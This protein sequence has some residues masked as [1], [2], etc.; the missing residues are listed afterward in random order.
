MSIAAQSCS[1][2]SVD[3]K[4]DQFRTWRELE[5]NP[6]DGRYADVS[7]LQCVACERLWLQYMV[8]YEAFSKSG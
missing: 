8:E 6:T 5:P 2:M 4:Y 3:A 1:C 7:I